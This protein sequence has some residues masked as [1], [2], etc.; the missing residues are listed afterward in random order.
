MVVY[1]FEG[2]ETFWAQ[3]LTQEKSIKFTKVFGL[4]RVFIH[5]F[6]SHSVRIPPND[7]L[8][9]NTLKS[10]LPLPPHFIIH[11]LCQQKLVLFLFY[12]LLATTSPTILLDASH[13]SRINSL[14][15]S[16]LYT[17]H[18][19]NLLRQAKCLIWILVSGSSS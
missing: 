12:H 1:D 5:N 17:L 2:I 13:V 14:L 6:L 7:I 3:R 16:S 8:L 18:F 11:Q 19:S 4:Y 9:W 15:R 10:F